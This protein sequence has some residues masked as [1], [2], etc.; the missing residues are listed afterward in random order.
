MNEFKKLGLENELFNLIEDTEQLELMSGAGWTGVAKS[1][2]SC[3]L[4][5]IG[6]GN[7][8]WV[9]TWTAECQA[10]CR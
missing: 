9:C 10:T 6:L 7:D 4:L 2:T 8:G 1:I 5:S 3:S